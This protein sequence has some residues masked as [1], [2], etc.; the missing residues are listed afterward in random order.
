MS[1][2]VFDRGVIDRLA[3]QAAGHGGEGLVAEV[4]G[5]A[6]ESISQ[7]VAELESA[8]GQRDRAR[9][10]SLSHRVKSVLRQ[11]GALQMGEA[12]SD[13]E[14]L[15]SAGDDDA[16]E[17]ARGVLALHEQTATALRAHLS[18]LVGG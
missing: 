10:R 14:R 15:A 1:L 7:S 17:K 13:V 18:T 2:P 6:I 3:E 4:L 16:F 8:V 12:A 11:V 5:E 9:V